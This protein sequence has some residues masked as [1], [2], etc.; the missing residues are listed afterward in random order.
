MQR[1]ELVLN[2]KYKISSTMMLNVQKGWLSHL[3]SR[4]Q[5][6][7]A[8]QM[9]VQEQIELDQA[10]LSKMSTEIMLCWLADPV[11][12]Q[13][14]S[15][16]TSKEVTVQRPR[17]CNHWVDDPAEP[18][19]QETSETSWS[20]TGK[21]HQHQSTTSSKPSDRQWPNKGTQHT[22]GERCERGLIAGQFMNLFVW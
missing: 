22:T 14:H 6:R 20:G 1:Q 3:Q 16:G 17:V 15:K 18:G 8:W 9:K 12:K 5:S 10:E 2:S 4:F 13:K 19:K 21:N 7:T 11:Q